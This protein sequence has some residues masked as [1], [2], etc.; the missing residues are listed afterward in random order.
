[1]TTFGVSPHCE[2][3]IKD[4][5]DHLVREVMLS[6]VPGRV[7]RPLLVQKLSSSLGYTTL[8]PTHQFSIGIRRW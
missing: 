4:L 2:S 3:G 1:M 7:S 5:V 6:I 8:P